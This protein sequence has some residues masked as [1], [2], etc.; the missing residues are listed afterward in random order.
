MNKIE[1]ALCCLSESG[2]PMVGICRFSEA[3]ILPKVRSVSRLPNGAKTLLMGLFPYYT[4]K[5]EGRNLSL[6]SVIP[7]YHDVAGDMLKSACER[8]EK[9]FPDG[10]FVPFVDASPIDEVTAAVRAGLGVRGKNGQLII[11]KFGSMV[12][13]GEIV[14]DIE[15]DIAD[16]SEMGCEGCGKCIRACP[17]GA[18]SWSGFEKS[19]CRSH[20]SQKKGELTEWEKEQLIIGGLAWG[21][22]ICTLA[23]PHNAAPAVTPIE[24]F[25]SDVFSFADDENLERLM[26]NRA[27]AW[28]GEKV[29]RRN[30]SLLKKQ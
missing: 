25:R 13:I 28:R 18:L 7:D 19:R 27:F 15:F 22:D 26:K 2:I 4:G 17:T 5:H 1:A 3:L 29:M 9:A 30:L 8:L 11:K 20:F 14:T 6:Y 24:R 21:C 23:C 10:Q 12:F 16:S